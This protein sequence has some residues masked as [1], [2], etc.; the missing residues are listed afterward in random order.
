MLDFQVFQCSSETCGH[1]YHPR[2]VAKLLHPINE[3]AAD[4]IQKKIFAGESFMCPVH[5]CIRCKEIEN[6]D[7]VELQFAVCRRCPKVYHTGCLPGDISSE[8]S[9]D[10]GIL[11]RAWKGLL[12]KNRILIYCT[13]HKIDEC[14][15][16]PV[17]DYIVFPDVQ[18]KK[19]ASSTDLRSSQGKIVAKKN[20]FASRRKP[21]RNPVNKL[22]VVKKPCAKT[23]AKQ[24]SPI[25]ETN[26]CLKKKSLN[27]V[28]DK[29]MQ[30]GK[31]KQQGS[32]R[33]KYKRSMTHIP[34]TKNSSSSTAIV[35][36]EM[37]MRRVDITKEKSSVKTVEAVERCLKG[38]LM[39]AYYSDNIVDKLIPLAQVEGSDKA[40]ENAIRNV[41]DHS[42]SY[43]KVDYESE[44]FDDVT[45][46]KA[47][48]NTIRNVEDHSVSD[49]KVDYESEI[50]DIMKSK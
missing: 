39:Q 3:S 19:K 24:D 41:K 38:A 2:C 37:E 5:K 35:E 18:E 43:P 8:S 20:G 15:L 30:F 4:Q 26:I 25:A 29:G 48:E 46:S 1:F 28:P 45:N 7:V 42:V 34:A 21:E 50:F 33:N 49:P 23:N 40:I 32:S 13:K 44:I 17:G 47:I 6:D 31:S 11:Q 12:Q 10:K 14:T 27:G 22:D 16:A 9:V 36:G